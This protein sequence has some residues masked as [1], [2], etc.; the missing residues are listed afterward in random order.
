VVFHLHVDQLAF[1]DL[2]LN[3]VLEP[4]TFQLMV[5][6]SSEDIRASGKLEIAGKGKLPVKEQVVVCPVDVQ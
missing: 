4:G 1:Y 3:L 6:S 5:G 2:D